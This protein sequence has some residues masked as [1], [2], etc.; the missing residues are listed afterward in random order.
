MDIFINILIFCGSVT[1]AGIACAVVSLMLWVANLAIRG[2][3]D[4]WRYL[5]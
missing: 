4:D 2:I 5:K 3:V 1:I